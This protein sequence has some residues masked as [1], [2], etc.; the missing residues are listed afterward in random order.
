MLNLREVIDRTITDDVLE[1]TVILD[2]EGNTETFLYKKIPAQDLFAKTV[3][4]ESD[5][6]ANLSRCFIDPDTRKPFPAD[7]VRESIK[8]APLLMSRIYDVI[9]NESY[10][11]YVEYDAELSKKKIT[12]QENG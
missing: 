2:L 6:I 4:E 10:R 8:K 9:L 7:V 3:R 12:T 11:Y 1:G 5:K